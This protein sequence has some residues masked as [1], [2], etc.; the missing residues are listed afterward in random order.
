MWSIFVIHRNLQSEIDLE[1]P[2]YAFS[3]G[4]LKNRKVNI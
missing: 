4:T 2:T 3:G 1:Y